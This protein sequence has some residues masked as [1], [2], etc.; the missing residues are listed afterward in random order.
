MWI[1]ETNSRGGPSPSPKTG[2][3]P[4]VAQPTQSNLDFPTRVI[5]INAPQQTKFRQNGI[6]TAKYS[7][8]SFF[9]CFLFEQF[10]RYSNI[11]FLTIALLQVSKHTNRTKPSRHNWLDVMNNFKI[12]FLKQIPDVSPTGRYTTMIPL[13]FILTVSAIKEIAEDIVSVIWF[14]VVNC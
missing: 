9:P 8:W 14:D 5:N 2:S 10:R 4:V 6:T 13:I 1:K 11:F 7:F 3:H 12:S